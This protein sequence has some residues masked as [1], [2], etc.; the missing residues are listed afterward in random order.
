[1]GCKFEDGVLR[2]RPLVPG[3][4][5][6]SLFGAG[7]AAV[8][9]RFAIREGEV[10]ELDVNVVSGVRVP[11]EVVVPNGEDARWVHVC[12]LRDGI[13]VL[14][15]YVERTARNSYSTE[16]ELAPGPYEV[17]AS[18]KGLRASAPLTVTKAGNPLWKV[19]LNDR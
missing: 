12:V 1:M 10:T 7:I 15:K 18:S 5:Q 19:V 2:T 17:L 6:L 4:Y 16:L 9:T 13:R 14:R 8:G 3:E 11:I